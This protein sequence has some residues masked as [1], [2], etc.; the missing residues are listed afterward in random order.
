MRVPLALALVAVAASGCIRA[1]A[2]ALEPAPAETIAPPA[3][4][5]EPVVATW[6]GRITA[7]QLGMLAHDRQ[8]EPLVADVQR[9]G[10]VFEVT[11]PPLDFRVDLAWPGGDGMMLIMVSTPHVGGKGQEYFT[12]MSSEAAQCLRIP[13]A[14]IVPGKWQVMAHSSGVVATDF[15]F[16]VTTVG[17][18]A[19]ILEGEPHSS[20]EAAETT[21][22]EALPCDAAPA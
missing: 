20:A 15:T 13:A 18:A 6:T 2:E 1:P 4:L 22:A 8:T 19:A 10:F 17:G 11:E 9:E 14:D 16:S 5:P 21:E 7:S 12:E 3:A